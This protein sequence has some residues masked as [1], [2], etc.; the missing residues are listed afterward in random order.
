[1]LKY[2]EFLLKDLSYFDTIIDST[3][4][5]IADR[6]PEEINDSYKHSFYRLLSEKGAP[7]YVRKTERDYY[8][9]VGVFN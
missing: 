1:L 5:Y 6:K 7:L 2:L 8:D 4:V 9:V 3:Y